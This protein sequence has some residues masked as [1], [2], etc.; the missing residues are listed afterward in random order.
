MM[1]AI[2]RRRPLLNQDWESLARQA[3]F[4][5]A[6]L[7]RLCCL[8]LRQLER[9]FIAHFGQPPGP[10]MRALKC[11]LARDLIA[12][13]LPNKL[14]VSDLCF[15]NQSHLC[16]EFRRFFGASPQ[17]FGPLRSAALAEKLRGR[18]QF[19][20]LRNPGAAGCLKGCAT[21]ARANANDWTNNQ[22]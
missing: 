10:W 18:Q 1:I 13:G 8:S 2:G 22:R 4:Q 16:H 15:G 7:A 3:R 19:Q 14:V 9:F 17:S 20:S 21:L 12:A 11:R 6:Q 5:P